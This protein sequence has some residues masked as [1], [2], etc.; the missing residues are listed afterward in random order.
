MKQP[1]IG[2]TPLYDK[3][4][5][6][7][8]MLPGYC[9]LVRAAGGI[10]L[11][12]P[13]HRNNHEFEKIA[14]IFDGFL[15]TG[16]ADV[17]PACYRETPSPLSGAPDKTRD[18]EEAEVFWYALKHDKPVF[19]ICRG[20]QYINVLLGGS[21]YQ[22]L[23]TETGTT[24]EHHMRPPYDR[25]V[26]EISI[27]KDTPL[28]KI[29]GMDS[30]EVN[31]YHHQGIKRLAPDLI[32]M[33]TAPDGLIEAVFMKDA[34]VMAVQWHPEF[35]YKKDPKQAALLTAFVDEAGR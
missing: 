28:K 20:I 4:K 19:G 2:I 8:W 13:Y 6:S 23:E 17:D 25:K 29:W 9:D 32:P 34:R 27:E 24:V 31:S 12:L 33:A 11:I 22:D 14:E 21:L 30:A 7:I 15:F 1:V 26:H 5:D 18:A 35:L 3:E 16:G 10:P